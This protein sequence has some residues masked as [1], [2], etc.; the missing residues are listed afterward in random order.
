VWRCE[1]AL[2]LDDGNYGKAANVVI[3]AAQCSIVHLF[4]VDDSI[5]AVSRSGKHYAEHC[6]HLSPRRDQRA[7]SNATVLRLQYLGSERHHCRWDGDQAW[8]LPHPYLGEK[9]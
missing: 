6:C 2:D 5:I 4:Q 9:G 1:G 3:W 8:K 7:R